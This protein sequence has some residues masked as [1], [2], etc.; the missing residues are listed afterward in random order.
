MAD[1]ALK[2]AQARAADLRSQGGS[3]TD[4]NATDVKCVTKTVSTNG[5]DLTGYGAGTGSMSED[6]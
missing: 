6:D 5:V 3:T 1:E 2:Q 4:L